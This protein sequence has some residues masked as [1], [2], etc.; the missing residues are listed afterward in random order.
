MDRTDRPSRPY[1]TGL[2]P[3]PS[4]MTTLTS[5]NRL[6]HPISTNTIT[7]P[8]RKRR[9]SQVTSVQQFLNLKPAICFRT[10]RTLSPIN[11]ANANQDK[12]SPIPHTCQPMSKTEYKSTQ[13]QSHHASKQHPSIQ[14]QTL[15]Y[16]SKETKQLRCH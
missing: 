13:C 2:L 14:S 5:I 16:N 12:F 8:K 4:S 6:R 10:Q 1:T 7:I 3:H 15:N 11:F 9:Y